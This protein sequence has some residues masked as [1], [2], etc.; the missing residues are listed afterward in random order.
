MFVQRAATSQI[1]PDVP[2]DRLVTDAQLSLQAQVS[3][4]L[5]GAP[6]FPQQPFHS[7]PV[8]TPKLA[9]A[10]RAIT[11]RV[12]PLLGAPR[13][14][15]A[16]V[17]RRVALQLSRHRAPMPPKLPRNL[18]LLEPHQP[19]RCQHAPLF[20]IELPILFHPHLPATLLPLPNSSFSLPSTRS[21]CCT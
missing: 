7:L 11:S 10:P 13:S 1:P 9:V 2:I 19:Q 6:R 8:P 17:R 5:F 21:P 3:G 20:P 14:I 15:P 18:R 16:V 4:D 12:G